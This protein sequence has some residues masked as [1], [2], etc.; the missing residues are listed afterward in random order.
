LGERNALRYFLGYVILKKLN[1]DNCPKCTKTLSSMDEMKSKTEQFIK[2]KNYSSVELYLKNPSNAMFEITV[3]HV[4]IFDKE[5][6]NMPSESSLRRWLPLKDFTPGLSGEHV[7]ILAEFVQ[8]M[9]ESDK[10]CT[11]LFDEMSIKS[12][13]EYVQKSDR[14]VGFT[15]LGD[16]YSD[17]DQYSSPAEGMLA[18]MIRGQVKPWK[19]VLG[20]FFV[21]NFIRGE[22]YAK[23]LQMLLK[24]WS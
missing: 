20:V 12:G 17:N 21:N 10:N 1:G 11:I 14:V 19:Y 7:K 5:F 4:Q 9:N 6:F 8:S 15:D 2:A 13:L 23:I 22:H 3:L 18:V 16:G 24:Y